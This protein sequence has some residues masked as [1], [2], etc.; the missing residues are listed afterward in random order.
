MGDLIPVS[1]QSIG[2]LANQYAAQ[3]A[4]ADYQEG[5]AK[6]TLRR[7]YN[8]L[9]VFADYLQAAGIACDPSALMYDP[10][11]WRSIGVTNG[12]VKGFVR[13]MLQSGY[14]IGSINIRLSTV[15]V[16][17]A[18]AAGAGAVA[19]HEVPLIDKVTGYRHQEGLNI[20]TTRKQAGLEVR[21]GV[22]KADPI[23]ITWEQANKLKHGQ[24]DTP[25]GRRDALLMCLLLDHGLRCGEVASLRTKDVNLQNGTL[26]FYR[27]KVDMTQTH[28]L[29]R[30]TLIAANQYL[31]SC[32]PG[33]YLLMGSR[34]GGLL[35]GRMQERSITERACILAE[36]VGVTGV[37]AHDARHAFVTFALRGGTDLKALQEAGGWKSIAMPARYAA[38][39]KIA[40]KGVVLGK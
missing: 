16:Y 36:R 33:E 38:P 27:K 12:L 39:L 13:W 26:I 4:F 9:Q 37:S 5:K 21:K 25:Q 14:A 15:K 31:A 6:N 1:S 7:Q 19:S 24:P 18:L 35:Q 30:D 10:E 2:Q 28:E 11:A 40:N 29:T 22:K 34:K 17:C 3:S 32:T 8:D 20:D 23:S